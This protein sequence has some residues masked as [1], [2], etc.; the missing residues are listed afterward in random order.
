MTMTHR[1]A[2]ALTMFGLLAG[3]WFPPGAV[4][5]L[6]TVMSVERAVANGYDVVAC[7]AS[8][9]G[10]ANNAFG[11]AHH[12]GY[13][14]YSLCPAGQGIV[15]RTV[16]GG[17]PDPVA[18]LSAARQILD[19]PPGTS[20]ESVSYYGGLFR[21]ECD[22]SIGLWASDGDANARLLWGYGGNDSCS[23]SQ[24]GD[25]FYS[26]RFSYPV[27]ATRLFLQV[28]CGFSPCS[29][30]GP[31]ANGVRLRDIAV[32][33]RDDVAPTVSNGRGGAWSSNAWMRSTQTIAFD[34]SDG[35]G[36]SH[37]SFLVDGAEV[38]EQAKACDFTRASP[39]PQEGFSGNVETAAIKPDGKH[40]LTLQAI[41]A[42]GNVGQASRDILVD[43]TP[44]A[45]PQGLT[46]V[47]G[48]GWRGTNGFDLRWTDPPETGVAPIAGVEYELC[49]ASGGSCTRGSKDGANIAALDGVRVP[50]AGDWTLRLWLRDAAGNKDASTAAAPLHLRFDDDPPQ[51]SLA[52]L[53]ASDPTLL[54]APATDSVSG[55]GS[56]QIEIQRAG[57]STWQPLPTQVEPGRLTARLD[58]ERLKDGTY[59]LRAD[60]YDGA[61]NGRVSQTLPDGN[62]AQL[63]LPLRIKTRLRVGIVRHIHGKRRLRY[64]SRARVKFGRPARFRGRLTTSERN[65]IA[66]ADVLVYSQARSTGSTQRLVAT[67]KTSRRGGFSYRTP[68]GPSRTIRFRY[69]GQPTVRSATHDIG[70]LVRAGTTLHTSRKRVVNGETARFH[71]R[72]RGGHIPAAGKLVELQVRLRSKWRT[73]ATTR[74]SRHGRWH[75]DYHFDGTR[76]RVTYRFRARIPREATYPYDGGVSRVRRVVV[77][78]A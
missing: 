42:A 45:Q 48:E 43:N 65:P 1:H 74:A 49:S 36:I 24:S 53:D 40:T 29:H 34:A 3:C 52:P 27:N 58:D 66:D 2:L 23:F 56:G 73:F 54:T 67:L 61:G 10:G 77:R 12:A 38:R 37:A 59:L 15:A 16:V 69:A 13:D 47:G 64:R 57:Q 20:I 25:G 75:Y 32:H 76:G 51:V 68:K 63:T 41:D 35:S 33:F 60:A 19:A 78:G 6:P 8:S 39:C 30:P 28:Q 46:L 5:P 50:S 44:P 31:V 55:I 72:L 26:V 21:E 7:D 11:P 22:Y 4:L 9:A 70:L 71:G 17:V 18:P 62:L 14:A